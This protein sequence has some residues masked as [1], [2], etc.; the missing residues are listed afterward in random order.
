MRRHILDIN[1]YRQASGQIQ[2][3]D[4]ACVQCVVGRVLSRGRWAII[5]RSGSMARAIFVD[6]EGLEIREHDT[7]LGR[8]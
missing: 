7:D 1:Y 5:D 4:L 8:A 6:D 2:V 3:I